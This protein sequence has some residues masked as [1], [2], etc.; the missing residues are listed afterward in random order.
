MLIVK[1]L[2][3]ESPEHLLNRFKK[4]VRAEGILKEMQ[5]HQFFQSPAELKHEKNKRKKFL[6]YLEK[7]RHA[8]GII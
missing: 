8:R 6:A 7:K 3:G 4:I 2:K 1:P 5:E